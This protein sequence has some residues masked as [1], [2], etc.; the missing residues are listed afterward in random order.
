MHV[1]TTETPRLSTEGATTAS[2]GL[3]VG[4]RGDPAHAG[5]NEPLRV[6]LLAPVWFPVPPSRY[7]GIEWIVSLLADGLV[8]AGH[9]VTLF[10]SGD[11]TT[12]AELAY[13]FETAPRE[14]IGQT[15]WELQ[16]LAAAL[17][18][19]SEFDV[20]N[21]HTG[22]MG[23]AL[24]GALATPLIHTVHGELTGAAGELYARIARLAPRLKLTSLSLNQ[25]LPQ[26]DLPWLANI[27][28]ALDFSAYPQQQPSRRDYLLFLGRMSPEKGCHRAIDVA[29]QLGVPLKIA[30]KNGEPAEQA[31]FRQFVEPHLG[32]AV[33]Y[34][35]EV[36]H[37]EKVELLGNARATLFPIEWEE[38]FGLVMIES[39]ACGTPV[40][41]TRRGAVSEVVEHG[42]SGIIVDDSGEM[43]SAVADAE[44]LDPGA[45]RRRAEERFAAER[46][47]SGYVEAYHA[48]LAA[49]GDPL[50]SRQPAAVRARA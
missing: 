44:R 14:R 48:A 4:E 28:N 1:E 15:F 10:A 17:E 38:P 11:S 16:H 5:T 3:A 9:E 2:V 20:V 42:V 45:I 50:A 37:D 7:G 6:A 35:G 24:G 39:M 34:C 33:E 49:T 22:L 47:V 29:R 40:V 27:P 41:A 30:G 25:R 12:K 21:D 13:V 36:T 32:D 31:Y 26:P 23:A 19:S 18:R 46:M 8:D 43:A